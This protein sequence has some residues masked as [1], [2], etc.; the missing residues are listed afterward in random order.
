MNVR[1]RGTAADA[2]AKASQGKD[3][4]EMKLEEFI[5]QI[6]GEIKERVL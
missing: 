4:L 1:K 3:S 2:K 5:A 6:A